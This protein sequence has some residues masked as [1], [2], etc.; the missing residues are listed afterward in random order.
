M[1]LEYIGDSA[2]Y[3]SGAFGSNIGVTIQN[4]L[5]K[6][7]KLRF[8]GNKALDLS[9]VSEVLIPPSVEVVFEHSIS[10]NGKHLRANPKTTIHLPKHCKIY[11][12]TSGVNLFLAGDASSLLSEETDTMYGDNFCTYKLDIQY[13]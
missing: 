12:D 10:F 8:I 1:D 2:F 3:G 6:C 7:N 5:N 11:R 4:L 13:Y 9:G